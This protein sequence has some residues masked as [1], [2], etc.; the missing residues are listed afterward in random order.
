MNKPT[1]VETLYR[2]RKL[3]DLDY[4][5]GYFMNTHGVPYIAYV[6]KDSGKLEGYD[7]FMDTL[8]I[9]FTNSNMND[10]EGTPI[11]AS[12]SSDGNGGD[13]FDFEVYCNIEGWYKEKGMLIYDSERLAFMVHCKYEGECK[14]YDMDKMSNFKLTSIHTTDKR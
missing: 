3:G 2:A 4:V 11:F 5:E 7:I 13:K 6:D 14:M 12:L 10:A 9:H 1:Q 8:A